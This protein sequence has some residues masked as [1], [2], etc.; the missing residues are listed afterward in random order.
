M[1]LN[2]SIEI[3]PS[4]GANVDEVCLAMVTL[5]KK[6]DVIVGATLNGVYIAAGPDTVPG[7]LYAEWNKRLDK[8]R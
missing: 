5:A 4:N 1:S 3:E 8:K 2:I 7:D 6:L